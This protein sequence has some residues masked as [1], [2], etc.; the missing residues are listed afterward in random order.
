MFRSS[1]RCMAAL[2]LLLYAAVAA[3]QIS[4]NGLPQ[5]GDGSGDGHKFSIAVVPDTQY[6][7]DEDRYDPAVL[8]KTFQWS[9]DHTREKNIVFT[10]QLGDIVNNGLSSE[11]AMASDAFKILDSN[12]IQYGYAAGTT[13]SMVACTTTCVA[14]PL[15]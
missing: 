14:P 9:V 10:V 8:A 11:F 4:T 12:V 5:S 1:C 6:L 2:A 3:A 13:T 15:T 7:F